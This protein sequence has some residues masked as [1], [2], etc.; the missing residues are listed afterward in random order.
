MNDFTSGLGDIAFGCFRRFLRREGGIFHQC[1]FLLDSVALFGGFALVGD[2]FIVN[3]LRLL[4]L[5]SDGSHDLT[6]SSC[7]LSIH[8]DHLG[9]DHGWIFDG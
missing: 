8:L 6:V 3:G 5:T 7:N 1:L 2:L 4:D 9:H